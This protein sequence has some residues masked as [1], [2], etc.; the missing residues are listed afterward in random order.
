MQLKNAT[1]IIIWQQVV[2]LSIF[3]L[4]LGN[5]VFDPA[6]YEKFLKVHVQPVF[7]VL[8]FST[9][10][11]TASFKME[12]TISQNSTHNIPQLQHEKNLC[13]FF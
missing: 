7:T 13:V 9:F 2:T 3:T 12:Q 4:Y 11:V 5:A 8:N 1:Y 10:Y 6:I